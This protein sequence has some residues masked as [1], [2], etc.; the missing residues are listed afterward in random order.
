LIPTLLACGICA[1]SPNPDSAPQAAGFNLLLITLDTTRADHLGSYDSESAE[2]PVL[3]GLASRGVRFDDAVTVAPLTLPSHA[4]ILTGLYPPNH[5]VRANGHYRLAPA[6]ETLAELLS[7]RGYET[8]AFVSAFVLDH[9]FG[10][11]QG[12]ETY[13]DAVDPERTGGL[14]I[15]ERPAGEVTDS[16]SRWLGTRSSK[17]PFFAWVHYFDP[18]K[19]YRAPE[20]FAS[21]YPDHPYAA[22]IA[23]MD[24]EIGRLIRAL[25]SGGQAERTLIVVVA[26]HGEPLGAHGEEVHGFFVYEAVMRVP[27]IVVLP[28]VAPRQP[29]VDDRVVS[30]VDIF[31]TVLDLLGVEDRPPSD[32]VGLFDSEG[33]SDRAVY[34]ESLRPSLDYGWAP[35]FGLRGH[36]YKFIQ[37]PVQEFY[38]LTSVEGED[39]NLDGALG[40]DATEV[41]D[42]LAAELDERLSRWASVDDVILE[43]QTLDPETRAR[44]EAL[45]YVGDATSSTDERQHDPKEMFRYY[46][47]L[48]EIPAL[49]GA[50]RFDE[51]TAALEEIAAAAPKSPEVLNQLAQAYLVGG[52]PQQATEL[53]RRLLEIRED[54]AT[55]TL[56]AHALVAQGRTDEVDGLVDR[57]LVLDPENGTAFIVRGDRAAA[58][59]RFDDARGSYRQALQVDPVRVGQLAESRLQRL[60]GR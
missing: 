34:M 53:L 26:D 6:H 51:A 45:G 20:P 39:R 56:L 18:H 17:R 48:G 27:L 10:L 35:L 37:A 52:D 13:D 1:C 54:A 23:Y 24:A 40:P 32:G 15:E 31:P 9:R 12:F 3:D 55:L 42:R 5:G 16:A 11:D 57:A 8:A 58:A 29:A 46:A 59:G 47:M 30:V 44:L 60:E 36:R 33:A 2:T 38:D 50:G 7:R 22:E 25:E 21:R 43:A 28:G 4:S 41:R 49:L 19:P 14:S